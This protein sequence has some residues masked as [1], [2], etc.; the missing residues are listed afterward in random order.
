MFLFTTFKNKHLEQKTKIQSQEGASFLS[1]KPLSCEAEV[2]IWGWSEQYTC[3]HR[4]TERDRGTLTCINMYI[5]LYYII[6]YM[7]YTC[8]PFKNVF[9]ASLLLLLTLSE[10]KMLRKL[11]QINLERFVEVI[12][13][14]LVFLTQQ[15]QSFHFS[16][17]LGNAG[18]AGLGS[19]LEGCCW[20]PSLW[21]S[22]TKQS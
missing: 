20:T 14:A 1:F 22:F 9:W 4:E 7:A 17:L 18:D 15:E 21:E 12:G 8:A 10:G 11:Y 6:L 5:K 2:K 19:L 16:A 13:S 3:I